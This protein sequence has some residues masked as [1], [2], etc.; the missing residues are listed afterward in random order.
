MSLLREIQQS[1]LNGDDIELILVKLMYLASHLG[2]RPL[3]EWV[4]HEGVSKIS[5]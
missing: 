1:L 5:K 4:K 2:S 3:E